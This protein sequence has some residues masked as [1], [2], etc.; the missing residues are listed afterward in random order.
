MTPDVPYLGIRAYLTVLCSPA[1][2]LQLSCSS[3]LDLSG[4]MRDILLGPEQAKLAVLLGQIWTARH[5][6]VPYCYD[7]FLILMAV[8][9][10]ELYHEKKLSIPL[11][12]A[13]IPNPRVTKHTLHTLRCIPPG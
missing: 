8:I 11:A 12:A 2:Q 6:C 5:A 10:P 3:G 4:I 1:D 7:I 9:N 13:F